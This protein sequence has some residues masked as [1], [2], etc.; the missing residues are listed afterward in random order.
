MPE[1]VLAAV[2][3]LRRPRCGYIYDLSV[4]RAR[5][6]RLRS[7]L[8][9]ATLLYAVKANSH[10]AVVRTLASALDGV[11]V[12][13]SGELDLALSVGARRVVVSGPAKT[14]DLLAA[15]SRAGA[16]INVESAQELRRVPGGASVAIRVNRAGG[17]LS[18]SHAMAGVPTQFGVDPSELGSLLRLARSRGVDVRGFHLHAAS[19]NLD[20]AAHAAFI[21][22]ALE[23]SVATADEHRLELRVVNVGGGLG[24]DYTGDQVFD[25]SVLAGGLTGPAGGSTP[26]DNAAELSEARA[27]FPPTHRGGGGGGGDVARDFDLEFDISSPPDA[28]ALPSGV[29]LPRG[30]ELILEPGRFLAADAGWYAAEVID[31]KQTQGRWF[32]VLRGGT[33]HFRLPAAWGYSHPFT[34]VPIDEWPYDWPRP[35]VSDVALDVAGELCTPRDI[36]ARDAHVTHLRIGDVLL[37]PRAGA[38]GWDISHHDFLRH[39]HPEFVILT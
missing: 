31:L 1:R 4:L 30:V 19:N 6:G 16:L 2:R 20:A 35:S 14:D 23:W 3:A 27:I 39:E 22:S 33:H 11:D 34:V 26:V 24:V 36:L 25:L 28:V 17:G 10:P 12:A 8:P 21:R 15:A 13:S 38:Y 5:A 9:H 29:E 32:A 7:A 37:F 18:G